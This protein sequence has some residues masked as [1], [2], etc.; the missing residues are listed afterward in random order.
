MLDTFHPLKL[1]TYAKEFDVP[2]YPF[3][4]NEE[5][6]TVEIEGVSADGISRRLQGVTEFISFQIYPP[7]IFISSSV[8]S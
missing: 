7:T 6:H 1:T 8:N 2:N 3:T 5:G 4:W